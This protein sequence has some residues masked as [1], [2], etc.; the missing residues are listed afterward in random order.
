MKNSEQRR[1]T[2]RGLQNSVLTH[3][4]YLKSLFLFTFSLLS[5]TGLFAQDQFLWIG[6]SGND[7]DVKENWNFYEHGTGTMS[8]AEYYP[9]QNIA[10]NIGGPEDDIAMFSA[11]SNIDC[12]IN[13]IVPGNTARRIGGIQVRGYQGTLTQDA[14]NRFIVAES[15]SGFWDGST[16]IQSTHPDLAAFN[17]QTAYIAYFDFDGATSGF[18]GSTSNAL[19]TLNY[20][21]LFAV[22]LTVTSGSSFIAPVGETRIRHNATFVDGTD[23][24]NI[25]AGTVVLSNRNGGLLSRQYELGDVRFYNLKISSAVHNLY[26]NNT[27]NCIVENN[28]YTS[29][30]LGVLGTGSLFKMWSVNG[31]MIEIRK[32]IIIGNTF[33]GPSYTAQD[34]YGDMTLILNGNGSDQRIFHTYDNLNFTGNLP[35]L[36]INKNV[37]NVIIDGPVTVNGGINFIQGIVHPNDASTNQNDIVSV[38]DLF[39][40]NSNCVVEACS[41]DSY[42]EGPIRCRTGKMIELPVGKEG[43]YRPAV[44]RP[45]SGVSIDYS[46]DNMYTAEYFPPSPT[47]DPIMKDITSL[48]PGLNKVDHCEVWAIQRENN[49]DTYAMDLELSY[50]DSS[51]TTFFEDKCRLVIAR[52]DESNS[53]WESHGSTTPTGLSCPLNSDLTILSDMDILTSDFERSTTNPD[54]FTFGDYGTDLCD[55]CSVSVYADYCVDSCT[56]T[57][58]PNI[59][60]GASSTF[61]SILWDFGMYGSDPSLNPSV[62]FLSTGLQTITVTV[63]AISGMDTCCVT[64]TFN[65]Y[66][67]GCTH[68]TS[69]LP[70]IKSEEKASIETKTVDDNK[71]KIIPNPSYNGQV[72]IGLETEENGVFNYD[73]TNNQGRTLQQGKISSRELNTIQT[74]DLAPGLY[75]ITIYL[76]DKRITEQII[77]GK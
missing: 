22:P 69:L 59:V 28:F 45:V 70:S 49:T 77:I 10:A 43:F 19:G 58:S 30:T 39:V 64:H 14:G 1:S 20:E 67:N 50:D 46:V 23:F 55:S 73:I 29:G 47:V 76:T 2:K 21:L 36:E 60:L 48:Q 26:F 74:S 63:C 24:D 52:W 54:L 31:G 16:T 18:V 17:T 8:P 32:D 12:N 15:Y 7:W 72:Q 35:F 3:K 68:T 62:T 53:Q 5:I 25:N 71:V 51:C 61:H 65:I 44:I 57:F 33:Y 37:G 41:D 34:A 11:I 66:V 9:G 40:V 42:C 75:F 6:G 13:F 38:N 4:N 56:F 27:A